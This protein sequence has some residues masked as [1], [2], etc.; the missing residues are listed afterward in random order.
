MLLLPPRLDSFYP[1]RS[2]A[3]PFP[4]PDV[5]SLSEHPSFPFSPFGLTIPLISGQYF[6]CVCPFCQPGGDLFSSALVSPP[7]GKSFPP[8]GAVPL[9]SPGSFYPENQ[10]VPLA[11]SVVCS[12]LHG[13][14]SL[15]SPVPRKTS[16]AVVLFLNP[17]PI[18]PDLWKL[19]PPF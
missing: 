10:E 6:V 12:P 17:C 18:I 9:F 7:P 16:H 1:Q 19:V 5:T 2:P 13:P 8:S 15:G 4:I 3:A 11:L 14:T